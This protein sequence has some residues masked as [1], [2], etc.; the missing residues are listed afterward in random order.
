MFDLSGNF[1]FS[2][3]SVKEAARFVIENGFAAPCT[4]S[5]TTKHIRDCANGKRNTAYSKIWQWV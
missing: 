1:E 2:F 3:L 5:G 4:I